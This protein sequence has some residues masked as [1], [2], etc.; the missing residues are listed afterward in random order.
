MADEKW[1]VSG[2]LAL[3]LAGMLVIL[4]LQWTTAIILSAAVHEMGHWL[5]IF[6]LTGR[7]VGVRLSA[8][9]ARI[10]LPEM[11]P[12]QECV[13]ALA[14]PMAGLSL[15]LL[16]RWMPRTAICALGHSVYNLLPI[17]PQDGGRALLCLLT[18]VM[19]PRKA[20]FICKHCQ[21]L[22]KC[23]LLLLACYSAFRYQL[24]LLPLVIVCILLFRTK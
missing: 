20:E 5:A 8:S 19:A 10:S 1:D 13:C 21:I 6:L 9:G 17:Y 16:A 24:G 3:L 22:C 7:G 2:G 14:G 18:M 23:F 12:W 15:L 4:P 11:Q